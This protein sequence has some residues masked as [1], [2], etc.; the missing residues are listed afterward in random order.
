ML[1]CTAKRCNSLPRPHAIPARND[2]VSGGCGASINSTVFCFRATGSSI[3]MLCFFF[4]DK[5]TLELS[6][7]SSLTHSLRISLGFI[8]SQKDSANRGA[9]QCTCYRPESGPEVV[10]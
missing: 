1:N 4:Q 3:G 9:A 10:S 5:P 6:L 7:S 2:G 8:I